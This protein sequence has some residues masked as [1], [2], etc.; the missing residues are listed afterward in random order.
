MLRKYKTVKIQE[1]RT[2]DRRMLVSP[3]KELQPINIT[4][5]LN[6]IS[7]NGQMIKRN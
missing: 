5:I 4:A 2:A 3:D 6:N 1:F 7:K